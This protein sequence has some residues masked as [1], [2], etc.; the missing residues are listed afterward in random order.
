MQSNQLI[1]KILDIKNAL[2]H[3]DSKKA[4]SKLK[5]D[6]ENEQKV[7]TLKAYYDAN[8]LIEDNTKRLIGE[9]TQESKN[10]NK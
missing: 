8:K 5:E 1:K 9:R 2:L 7:P 6:Y 10:Q 3:Y 4:F